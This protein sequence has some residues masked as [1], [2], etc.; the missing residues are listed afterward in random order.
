MTFMKKNR[1]IVF[2][3]ALFMTSLLSTSVFA[4]AQTQATVLSENKA[5]VDL[6]IAWKGEKLLG[7]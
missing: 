6:L 4:Y 2:K 5:Q 1:M 3:L 7:R